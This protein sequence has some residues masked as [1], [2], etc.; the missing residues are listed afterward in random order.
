VARGPNDLGGGG[1]PPRSPDPLP[2]FVGGASAGGEALSPLQEQMA[3]SETAMKHR[4]VDVI[5]II[6]SVHV[7]FDRAAIAAID[8]ATSGQ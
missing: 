2:S 7:A 8:S 3:T 1:P 6:L 5:T 4:C